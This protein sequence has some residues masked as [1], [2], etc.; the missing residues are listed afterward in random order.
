MT[1]ITNIKRRYKYS[2]L[3]NSFIYGFV[4]TL[5][6]PNL[7]GHKFGFEHKKVLLGT[8]ETYAEAKKEIESFLLEVPTKARKAR[9]GN[10]NNASYAE[11]LSNVKSVEE[12]EEINKLRDRL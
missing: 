6:E 2:H 10:L 12:G 7:N 4:V 1:T 11:G 8:C 5:K 9:L 3:R